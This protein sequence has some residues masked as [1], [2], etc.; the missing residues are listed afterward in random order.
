MVSLTFAPPPVESQSPSL[1][2]PIWAVFYYQIFV[3]PSLWVQIPID[4]R[5]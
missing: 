2:F 3:T 1:R 4:P 5:Y